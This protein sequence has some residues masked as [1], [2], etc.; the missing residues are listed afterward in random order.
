MKGKTLSSPTYKESSNTFNKEACITEIFDLEDQE[1]WCCAEK[2]GKEA[3]FLQT[4][5]CPNL[6]NAMPPILAYTWESL[7]KSREV[8]KKIINV[9]IALFNQCF[10][11]TLNSPGKNCDICNIIQKI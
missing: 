5:L 2:L 10:H 11:G 8:I 1:Q 4:W 3:C 9:V 7:I 6:W